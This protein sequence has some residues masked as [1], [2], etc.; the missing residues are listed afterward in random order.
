M[1]RYG[2]HKLCCGVI[3][4]SVALAV[5][6]ISF[7]QSGRGG[8]GFLFQTP[9]FSFAFSFGYSI[10]NAKSEI[11]EF[12]QEQLTLEKSDFYRSYLGGEVAIQ[13][14]D[15][16][17]LV[18]G[19]GHAES[20]LPSE[21]RDWVDGDDL[22]IEQETVFST[23]PVTVSARYYLSDRGRQIGRFA[24]IPK[25]LVPFIGAGGGVIW[26]NF[27]QVGDFVDFETLAIFYDRFMGKGTAFQSHAFAGMDI[28]LNKSL[29][30]TTEGRYRWGRGDLGRD[31]V[32]FDKMDLAGIQFTVSIGARF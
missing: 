14:A 5:P 23:T 25:R 7:A 29:F 4:L 20:Y 16:L 13:L 17:D 24:W 19:V 21:F 6:K 27:E 3:A 26:Y 10:P 2:L 22:P 9:K 15:R 18:F 32:G 8:E 28:S 30:L 31:F 1:K 11:F 12:A